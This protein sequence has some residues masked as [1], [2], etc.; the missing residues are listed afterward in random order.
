MLVLDHRWISFQMPI[1]DS[2]IQITINSGYWEL[3]FN[4]F[5]V[6]PRTKY[7]SSHYSLPF[8]LSQYI[9]NK[10]GTM[11]GEEA[12]AKRYRDRFEDIQGN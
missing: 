2:M 3:S 9:L 6:R 12:R 4:V 10:S 5:F 8:Q 11:A 7:A 1:L